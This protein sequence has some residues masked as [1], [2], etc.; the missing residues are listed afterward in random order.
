MSPDI[1]PS[2]LTKT[3]FML[4]LA[5]ASSHYLGLSMQSGIDFHT[6]MRL[7]RSLGSDRYPFRCMLEPLLAAATW[8]AERIHSIRDSY[9]PICPRCG[10]AQETAL[11]CLWSCSANCNIGDE[12]A[13]STQNLIPP[14]INLSTTHPC[15][16]LR[17]IP[18]NPL[19]KFRMNIYLTMDNF[20]ANGPGGLSTFGGWGNVH[21]RCCFC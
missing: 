14:A 12:A 11:H 8:P 9:D 10:L 18:Q 5:K 2:A 17:G 21:F 6:T 1:V 19:P 16:W 3:H 15:L 7:Y 4:D 13:I 20:H